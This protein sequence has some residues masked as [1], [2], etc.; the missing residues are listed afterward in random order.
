MF[1]LS[2][3]RECR[4]LG[5]GWRWCR[6]AVAWGGCEWFLVEADVSGDFVRRGGD[7]LGEALTI[8]EL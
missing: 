4:R 6:Y 1:N 2:G 7:A 8:R 5:R 3:H